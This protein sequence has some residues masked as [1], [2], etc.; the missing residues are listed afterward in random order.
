[1]S[2]PSDDFSGDSSGMSPT[3][4]PPLNLAQVFKLWFGVTDRVSR[5]AYAASGLFLGTV[6]YAVEAMAIWVFAGAA[7]WPWD[8]VNPLLAA[9][10]AM[11]QPGP[12]WLLWALFFWTLPFLWISVTMTVRRVADAGGSPWMGFVVLIPL[13]NLM[14]MFAMC[15]ARSRQGAQW[16]NVAR[17]PSAEGRALSAVFAIAYSLLIGAVMLATSVYLFTSYGASLF[18][19][20]PFLMGAAAAFLYNRPHPRGYP[21]SVGIGAVAVLFAAT[22]MLLFALEGVICIA[23]AVPLIVPIGALGGVMGKAIADATR[24]PLGDLLAT[25]LVLPLL[26]GGESLLVH[27]RQCMVLSSVEIEAPP[28]VVWRRV[29]SFP[30]LPA[31]RPWYFRWGIAC[32][33]RARIVGRGA[34]AIRYCEFTTGAFVEPITVWDEPRRLAFDVTQQPPP[35][36][37]L[38]PY[39]HVHPPHLDGFLRSTHG[40]FRLIR[41]SQG[42]TRLEGRTWY[43]VDMFPQWYWTLWSDLL[44]HRIHLRILRHVERLAEDAQPAAR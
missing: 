1:M 43:N 28:E 38:S 36:F 31:E 15:V 16:S 13:L 10:A 22:A 9:R 12:A 44:I 42:R 7:F 23:M 26:A 27:P 8:F 24:R 19:G 3:G 11:L 34:G 35:M 40:E 18:L 25:A 33:E 2:T 4:S 14:F 21:A 41:L 39:R 17:D 5:P 29:V 30:D 37:E 6:K 32:P 20:T